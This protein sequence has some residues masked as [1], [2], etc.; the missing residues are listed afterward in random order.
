MGMGEM[1]GW[2]GQMG[3]KNGESFIKSVMSKGLSNTL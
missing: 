2:G 1:G 3:F